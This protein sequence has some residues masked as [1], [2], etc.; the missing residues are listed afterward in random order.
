[1]FCK[2]KYF[3]QCGGRQ[4]NNL[5]I[6]C[7]RMILHWF[8]NSGSNVIRTKKKKAKTKIKPK[9]F[10]FLLCSPY[11]A[12]RLDREKKINWLGK[13][14]YQHMHTNRCQTCLAMNRWTFFLYSS[15]LLLKLYFFFIEFV[16]F[17]CL[18]T[19]EALENFM[20][21][22]LRKDN[23]KTWSKAIFS[24]SFSLYTPFYKT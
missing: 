22:S 14:L 8:H 23:T 13:Y 15:L 6:D 17:C 4:T 18:T 10:S 2:F 1:M 20:S 16:V 19:N 21:R 5:P 12:S 11:I 7:Y 3:A 24:F 9:S